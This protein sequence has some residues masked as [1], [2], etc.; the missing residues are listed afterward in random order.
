MTAPRRPRSAW[1]LVGSTPSVWVKV[2]RAGQ[3]LRRFLAKSRWYL[4]RG[5]LR[6]ACSS[7]VRSFAWSG[8]I[9]APLRARRPPA[10]PHRRRARRDVERDAD[11]R[12]AARDR[13]RR[14]HAHP[15]DP[16][17]GVPAAL[18]LTAAAR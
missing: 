18:A 4:V 3:R 15:L 10:T 2:Q 17:G 13:R 5:L 11:R 8:V 9:R 12:R 16:G 1:V 7:R 14:R 6:A